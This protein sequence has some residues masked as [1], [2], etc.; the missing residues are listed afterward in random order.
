MSDSLL[1][2]LISDLQVTVRQLEERVRELER[3]RDFARPIRPIPV[4]SD[5]WRTR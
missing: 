1:H 2:Q 3:E 4:N 5:Y